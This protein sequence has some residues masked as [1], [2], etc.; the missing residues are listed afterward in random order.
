M[1]KSFRSALALL[2]T[3]VLVAACGGDDG[4]KGA[5]GLPSIEGLT[6]DRTAIL[7]GE[8]ATATWTGV[9]DPDAKALVK[10]TLLPDG[11]DLTSVKQV[12][13][14]PRATTTYTL[15]AS[16]SSGTQDYPFTI[17]VDPNEMPVVGL[18]SPAAGTTLREDAKLTLAAS[19]TDA[20]DGDLS[21]A[22]QWTSSKDGALSPDAEGKVSLTPGAHAITASATDSKGRKGSASVDVTVTALPAATH[23]V[24]EGLKLHLYAV[25]A[26]EVLERGVAEIP[27]TGLPPEQNIFSLVQHPT[28]PWVYAASLLDNNWGNAR[29]D[30]FVVTGTGITYGGAAFLY[31][32][33]ATGASCAPTAA[34]GEG[35]VGRCAPVGLAFN[36]D[37]SRLY[38][39]E[40]SDDV[41]HTFAI[42]S[43]TGAATFLNTGSQTEAHG[44]TVHPDGQYLYNGSRTF[45]LAG[46]VNTP[47]VDGDG[48]T[49]GNAGNATQVF[50]SSG[51]YMLLSTDWT[52][53]AS[54]YSLTNPAAPTLVSTLEVAGSDTVRDVA[55]NE[56]GTRLLTT[57]RNVVSTIAFDGAALT[58]EQTLTL[59]E[60]TIIQNRS[61]AFAAGDSR[62]VTAWFTS[63]E[64]V[65]RGGATVY[66]IGAAGELAAVQSFDYEGGARAILSLRQP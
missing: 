8:S 54:V 34:D 23:V 49:L 56:A 3:S 27:A 5:S 44:L 28:R 48:N 40:D 9:K 37:G 38:V 26:D 2:L 12:T 19:A 13:V 58:L 1:R 64:G 18:T 57:G 7:I 32:V 55:I 51:A 10:V 60:P 43:T 29:L 35:A 63:V 41:V 53:A 30:R 50:G 20:E 66:S 31:D 15:R 45:E 36:A 62:A 24:A 17:T 6:Y 61:V 16:S 33:T 65:R 59:A 39:Q 4:D 14:S 42:D 25:T 47:I 21:G 52:S 11:T 22:I 46:D